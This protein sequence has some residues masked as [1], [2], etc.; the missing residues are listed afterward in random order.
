MM[1]AK[2]R[3]ESLRVLAPGVELIH[4]PS[5]LCSDEVLQAMTATLVGYAPAD[6][7]S[8]DYAREA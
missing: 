7:R 5:G 8:C 3:A 4:G 2:S 1:L 6:E